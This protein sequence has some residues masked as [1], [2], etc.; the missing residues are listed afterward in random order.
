[1]SPQT[2]TGLLT[3]WTFD[4]SMRISFTWKFKI[5]EFNRS[6]SLRNYSMI[7]LQSTLIHVQEYVFY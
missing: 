5:W 1:M 7:L 6:V 3:G 4:S 2:V